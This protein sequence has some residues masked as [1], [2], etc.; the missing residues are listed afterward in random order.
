[1]YRHLFSNAVI[2]ILERAYHIHLEF[3]DAADAADPGTTLPEALASPI[4][5]VSPSM[6]PP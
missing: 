4:F 1:M 2:L 3:P 5:Q 6:S